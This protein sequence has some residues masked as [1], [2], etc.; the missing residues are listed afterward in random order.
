MQ[1]PFGCP[2][3]PKGLV[4]C[5][6]FRGVPRKDCL[7]CGHLVSTRSTD[8]VQGAAAPS[9]GEIQSNLHD[10]LT[11]IIFEQ[12]PLQRHPVPNRIARNPA[13]WDGLQKRLGHQRWLIKPPKHCLGQVRPQV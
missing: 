7:H 13:V 6:P 11:P 10:D 1:N 9:V 12:L 5:N 4:P 2:R 8:Q 3:P